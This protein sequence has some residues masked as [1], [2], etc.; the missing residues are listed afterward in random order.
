M[1]EQPIDLDALEALAQ[2]ATPGP[3][4]WQKNNEALCAGSDIVLSSGYA[5][6]TY[7][8]VAGEP[9]SNEDAAFIAALNPAATLDLIAELRA[10]RQRAADFA[11]FERC[12]STWVDRA[13]KAEEELAA[14]RERAA[15]VRPLLER[16]TETGCDIRC[17]CSYRADGDH[18]HGP[19]CP[20]TLARAELAA[21]D[22]EEGET[23]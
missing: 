13:T 16:V 15:R 9:P 12:Y 17:L 4:Y 20:V 6:S 5:P 18:D 22:G 21:W 11:A 2:A 1:T 19:T 10:H 23:P 8:Q 7:D 14:H 3:W